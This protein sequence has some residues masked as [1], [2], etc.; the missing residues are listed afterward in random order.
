MYLDVPGRVE[1]SI[2]G[3]DESMADFTDPCTWGDSLGVRTWD[4]NLPT[5]HP[6]TRKASK[7]LP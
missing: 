3:E 7:H 1:V 6:S 4:P 5:G 2:N